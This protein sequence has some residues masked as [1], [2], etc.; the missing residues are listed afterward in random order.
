MI[1]G[2]L[3]ADTMWKPTWFGWCSF[4]YPWPAQTIDFI[5]VKLIFIPISFYNV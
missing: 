1:G 5:R 3:Y 4:G 2:V